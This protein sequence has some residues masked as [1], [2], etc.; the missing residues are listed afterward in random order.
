MLGGTP[1]RHAFGVASPCSH[2]V[3]LRRLPMTKGARVAET[4]AMDV[5]A[6]VVSAPS[7][8]S[9]HRREVAIFVEPSPFSHVSGMKN[10]FE[11]LIKGLRDEGDEVVV[12]TPDASPP[13]HF[14]GAKVTFLRHLHAEGHLWV[15]VGICFRG[16]LSR[17]RIHN[18]GMTQQVGHS[19][20]WAKICTA[21]MC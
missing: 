10:R 14:C 9:E 8:S 13:E 3:R 7:S 4:E 16:D 11:C 18:P 2:D 19:L 20:D 12:Y 6:G 5:K 21:Y 17:C 15:S 1:M